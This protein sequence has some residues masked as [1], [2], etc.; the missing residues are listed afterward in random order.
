MHLKLI[1]NQLMEKISQKVDFLD[2]IT[3]NPASF[4]NI[5]SI[6]NK[7]KPKNLTVIDATINYDYEKGTIFK[8]NDHI[9][10]TGMSILRGKQQFLKIDFIDIS[11]LYLKSKKGIITQCCG[12]SLDTKKVFPSHYLCQVTILAKA[13]KIDSIKAYLYNIIR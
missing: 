10:K 1:T 2:Y 5:Y 4:N 3:V 12:Q 13:L 7:N 11:N 6:L 8:V 9:N